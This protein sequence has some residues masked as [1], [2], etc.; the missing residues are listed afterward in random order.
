MFAKKPSRRWLVPTLAVAVAA[1][2][3]LTVFAQSVCSP[4]LPAPLN[5]FCSNT[6]ARA[7][8][9]NTNFAVLAA[10]VMGTQP[11]G[12]TYNGDITQAPAAFLRAAVPGGTLR[13]SAN[14]VR[15][16]GTNGDGRAIA[17]DTNDKLVINY[18][19]EFVGGTEVSGP[20][21]AGSLTTSGAIAGG[22]LSG[23]GLTLGTVPLA[24]NGNDLNIGNANSALYINGNLRA[25]SIRS[26]NCAYRGTAFTG[27]GGFTGGECNQGEF[28]RGTRCYTATNYLHCEALCCT[29]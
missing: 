15:L 10:K 9:V 21:T 2:V 12:G 16:Q 1:L 5:T 17:T 25:E 18:A 29:P 27:T 22:A 11:V 6:P 26:R 8:E 13:V 23:T 3:P 4:T 28:Q 14:A 24:T 19:G 20:L 7:S